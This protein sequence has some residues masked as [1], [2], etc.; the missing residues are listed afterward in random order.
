MTDRRTDEHGDSAGTN[1]A[2]EPPVV[3]A[4]QLAT[5]VVCPRQHE[6]E[7]DRPIT[8]RATSDDRVRRRRRELLRRSIVAGLQLEDVTPDERVAAALRRLDRL[9]TSSEASYLADEQ[10][11]YDEQAIRTAI[12][13][14]LSTDGHDHAEDVV[15]T[16]VTVGYERDGIRYE[17]TVD[18]VTKRDGQYLGIKYLPDMNG[19]LQVTWYDNNVE[20]FHNGEGYYPRQIGSFVEAG[21][22][23]QGLINEYGLSP[24]YDFA[25]TG[26][27]ETTRPAYESTGEIHVETEQRRFKSAFE[28]ERDELNEL[29]EDRAD[30]IIDGKTDPKD[31][32]FSRIA[33]RSCKYCAYRDGC[34]DWME[35]EMSFTDRRLSEKDGGDDGD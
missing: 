28:T 24:D 10:A 7:Y 13:R 25:Y 2:D 16:D 14:Y 8:P 9:W 20:R 22:A 26:L 15:D 35:S 19:V 17:T 6:F 31:W 5:H 23:I 1:D 3:T 29:I 34:P 18:A 12:E 11:Q 21:V 32:R 4:S 30:A 27:L 33:E